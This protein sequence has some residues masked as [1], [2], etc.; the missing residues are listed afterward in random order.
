MYYLYA[1]L[2]ALL[3]SGCCLWTSSSSGGPLSQPKQAS[4]SLD[5]AFVRELAAPQAQAALYRYFAASPKWEIR[6]MHNKTFA[7]RLEKKHNIYQASLNGF[8]SEH[9]G[10]TF[11][12]RRVIFAFDHP[13]GF[14]RDYGQITR[15]DGQNPTVQMTL[16]GSHSG[17]PGNSSY[18][19]IGGPGA[20]LEIFEQGPESSRPF[21][22]QTLTAIT[23]ELRAVLKHKAHMLAHGVMPPP[24]N[25]M[26]P[27]ASAPSFMVE[28]DFQGGI[29][30]LRAHV[31]PPSKGVVFAKVFR[32]K[33]NQPLS[34]AR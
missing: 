27:Y 18:L 13:H 7:V 4:V 29:F 14:G 11:R 31:N 6:Q 21:T 17:S 34:V 20:Y 33:D 3:C 9:Q 12:Q 2:I 32:A 26:T 15:T 25:T 5:T 1:P 19:I 24:L 23:K 16:E 28:D 10:S 8:Y 22:Q 30:N